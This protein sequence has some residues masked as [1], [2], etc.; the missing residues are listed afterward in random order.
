MHRFSANAFSYLDRLKPLQYEWRTAAIVVNPPG[1]AT[2]GLVLMAI[3]HGR[4]GRFPTILRHQPV[5]GSV[6]TSYEVTEI[7]DLPNVR[8]R[9]RQSR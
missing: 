9:S 1:L 3:L 4:D 8:D 5:A 6:P 7:I 2:A